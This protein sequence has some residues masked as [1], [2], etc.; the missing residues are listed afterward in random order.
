MNRAPSV[1]DDWWAAHQRQ[2]GGTFAKIKEPDGYEKRLDKKKDGK[3]PATEKGK[4]EKKEKKEK[5][6][7]KDKEPKLLGKG[8][9]KEK[10]ANPTAR[11][12]S[13]KKRVRFLSLFSSC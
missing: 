11:E 13:D 12:P 5:K 4:K 7:K 2:C 8:D 3:K 9:K 6:D 10:T 1:H